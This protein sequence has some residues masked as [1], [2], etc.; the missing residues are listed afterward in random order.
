L[1]FLEAI[2]AVLTHSHCPHSPILPSRL[3]KAILP[4]LT[5]VLVTQSEAR[6]AD[7]ANT[8]KNKKGKKRARGYEGDEVFKV[9]REVVCAIKEDGEVLMAALDVVR[10]VLRNPHLA[11]PIH[12]LTSRV[13]LSM[14]L[15]L[16]QMSPALLSPD[17]TL[18][19]R[20]L[21]RVREICVELGS[22]T[23]SAMSK[24]LGIVIRAGTA[25]DGSEHALLLSEDV[26]RRLDLLL[27]PR[28]PPLVRSIPHVES[29]S[30]FRAEEGLEEIDAR[31]VLRLGI[32]NQLLPVAQSSDDVLTTPAPEAT[33]AQHAYPIVP[34][35]TKSTTLVAPPPLTAQPAPAPP[36]PKATQAILPPPP[37]S[38]PSSSVSVSVASG[39]TVTTQ[40]AQPVHASVEVS[41]D[42]E[43]EEEMPTIDMDSDSD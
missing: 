33:A 30:L 10:L 8:G 7:D 12:S 15:A 25:V 41:M 16:T 22:G 36:L 40:P 5:V 42:D 38:L 31:E 39:S 17:L 27:H 28:V 35:I 23:T 4:S 11:P 26:H 20:V 24:S 14:L 9:S 2:Q 34:P 29:L 19:G 1:L 21:G 6:R 43:D 3:A 18:H 32:A 37:N 13:L